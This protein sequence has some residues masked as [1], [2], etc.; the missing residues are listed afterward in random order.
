MI[1]ALDLTRLPRVL[2]GASGVD[3]VGTT[4]R[5]RKVP[6]PITAS[7]VGIGTR[8]RLPRNPV[9]AGQVRPPRRRYAR[10]KVDVT[11][12]GP[13]SRA[14]RRR[15]CRV[16]VATIGSSEGSFG[17]HAAPGTTPDTTTAHP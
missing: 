3:V 11:E 7:N 4:E 6:Q 10:L 1:E 5:V 14:G 9:R 15:R 8:R 2:F 12:C 16:P 13:V 17:N